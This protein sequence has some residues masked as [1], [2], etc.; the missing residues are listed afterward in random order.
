M[1]P[2]LLHRASA[3][4]LSL[5]CLTLSRVELCMRLDEYSA[6][7]SSPLGDG[8]VTRAALQTAADGKYKP[9]RARCPYIHKY[10][11]AKER[12]C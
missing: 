7:N 1:A 6:G 11:A 4:P 9:D 3:A 2:R 12:C 10:N 8:T 5:V